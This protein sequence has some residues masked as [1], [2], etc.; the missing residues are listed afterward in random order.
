[1]ALRYLNA[2]ELEKWKAQN[3]GKTYFD[4]AGN[5]VS[6]PS[7]TKDLG[8]LG[9]LART[10]SKPFRVGGGA[11][12]ELGY[13]VGDIVRMAQG[14][15]PL[16][17]PEQYF[18]LTQEESQ[19]LYKD[20]LK[21]GIKSAA[22]VMSYAV[23]AGAAKGATTVGARIGTAAAR[24]AGAGTLGSF[25]LSE[26][27]KE[28]ETALKGAGL[29]FLMGGALQGVGE[30]VKAVKSAKIANKLD[31]M[32]DEL[33]ASALK[34]DIGIAP[35]T[36]QGKNILPKEVLETAN[37]MG[38]KIKN[39]E[40]LKTFG[41]ALYESNANVAN[42]A[43]QQLDDLG[44]AIDITDIKKPLLEQLAK[45]KSPE[46]KAP[47]QKVL[48]SIDSATGGSNVIPA[49]ELLNLKREWGKLGNW[50][51]LMDPAATTTAGAFEAAYIKANDLLDDAFK[52]AGI[53]GFKEANKALSLAIDAD[54][55]AD[56]A[57]A[58]RANRPLWN[59]MTQ[60]AAIAATVFGGGGPAAAAGAVGSKVMQRYAEPLAEGALRGASKVA[61]GASALPQVL[62]PI[63]NVGQR[64]VPAVAGLAAG[65]QG[66]GTQGVGTQPIYPTTQGVPQGMEAQGISPL[67]L[68]L[69]QEVLNGNISAAEANAVLSLLGMSQDKDLTAN[70]SKAI[71]LQRSL[72]TLKSAWEGAGAGTKFAETLGINIGSKTRMLDQ[73]KRAVAED[74]GR[75]QSQ[76]A[77]N[78]EEREEFDRMMPNSWDSP[79][80]V[81]QKF[82][83]IQNRIDS[84]KQ[85]PMLY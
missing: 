35:T 23:P 36:K 32:A 55:W 82:Q 73:A 48:D 77:I 15:N 22:G 59:D 33:Q 41:Q 79:E 30:G 50:N 51:P 28:L 18:G 17:R 26:S 54:N 74:L 49:S 76:G 57:I 62:Q 66:V 34:K 45:T 83:A 85:S 11:L 46:L 42:V 10:V 63:L 38:V 58:N 80:V 27:G 8:F 29:G 40:D 43:A 16:E 20:P 60:D 81:Q 7:T 56:R 5:P 19:A 13:T 70:Q 61:R 24:G 68:M 6:V 25:S 78:A 72:D 14:K 52:S 47:I 4:T 84:Y 75:L 2:E 64:A 53:T 39:P 12:Q 9:N 69:A 3:P 71:A 1:M 65:T 21:E 44:R 37:K 31:D 67:N